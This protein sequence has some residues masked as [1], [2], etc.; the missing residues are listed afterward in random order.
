MATTQ[1]IGS[2]YVPVFA[3]PI[4]WSNATAYEPLTIVTHEG[5]SYTSR[6]YVPT[7]IG[8][9]DTDY[10]ALTGNYN[11]QVEQYRSEVKTLDGRITANT[12]SNSTQ[13]AQLAGT[14]D[15]GLKTLIEEKPYVIVLG[16]SWSSADV[17]NLWVSQITDYNMLNF[18]VGGA[19]WTFGTTILQQLNNAISS[20]ASNNINVSKIK[21]IIVY[22]GANDYRSSQPISVPDDVKNAITTFKT[23]KAS[24]TLA[25]VPIVF[26]MTSA[27][28]D[29]NDTAGSANISHH[30]FKYF[31]AE[32]C[33]YLTSLGFAID[34]KS[35]LWCM[36][37]YNG[38]SF[39]DNWN[40]D[41]LHPSEAGQNIIASKMKA[42]ID[43]E[44]T[45]SRI[46]KYVN[47]YDSNAGLRLTGN[48]TIEDGL[49]TFTGC[50]SADSADKFNSNGLI[51]NFET[52]NSTDNRSIPYCQD[53][54]DSFP[55]S[56]Y[57]NK[58]ISNPLN[59]ALLID[60][61]NTTTQNFSV[62]LWYNSTDLSNTTTINL[63]GSVAVM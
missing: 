38:S 11:A 56:A 19:S 49:L 7:G 24:S 35:Y 31:A 57:V 33:N 17:S 34:Y 41:N 28:L 61:S 45:V 23:T 5:N 3:D 60:T 50:I 25:N 10:W 43:G 1:Y 22:S 27:R 51:L 13:D 46:T 58:A 30:N 12:S 40:S 4:E 62:Y 21:K 15:S 53:Y 63:Q 54:I 32:Y 39:T 18:A 2:R 59:A 36:N 20:V 8:I 29:V 14:S 26:C 6:Q 44:N 47:H 42:V 55:I 52:N 48:A 9:S 37:N 16:D